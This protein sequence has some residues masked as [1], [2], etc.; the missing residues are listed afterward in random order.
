[1]R[2]RIW[3]AL[4]AIYL[5]WG[6]TYL[7]IRYAVESIPPFL[8]AGT[9]FLIAG[10]VL[11]TWRRLA[12]DPAPTARQWRSTAIIGLLLLL[13]GNGLVS[14]AEQ[15]VPS[16]IAALLIGS[17]PLWMVLTESIR[18]GGVK[19]GLSAVLGLITGFAGILVLIWPLLTGTSEHLNPLGVV[20]LLFAAFSWA[21]GSVYSKSA[22]LPPSSL[23]TT[24]AEMLTGS[25]GLYFIGALLDEWKML[26]FATITARSWLGLAYLTVLG[27][28]VGFVAYAWLLR[29]APISLVA[30]YA[31]VNPL[32]AILLGSLLAQESFS[33]RILLAALIIIGSVVLINY[34]RQAKVGRPVAASA[35]G[36]LGRI[37]D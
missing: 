24:A 8:M 13:G 15:T 7:A 34:S 19:P 17:I 5:I 35:E 3:I 33:A 31:Y 26:D 29:H 1:M 18:R 6:S 10:I 22:E 23:M 37:K 12:G 30:T 4:L 2:L 9:R 20:A 11:Y 25:L 27:S 14:W 28:L 16:G 32:V 36:L 21:V